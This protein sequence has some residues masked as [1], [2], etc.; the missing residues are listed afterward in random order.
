MKGTSVASELPMPEP[1]PAAR[2]A[3][4]AIVGGRER[5]EDCAAIVP[6]T[7]PEGDRAELLILAD[8]MGGHARG[9]VA[10]QTAINAFK[11]EFLSNAQPLP[12]RLRAGLAA[13]NEAIC[14]AVQRDPLLRG[15]GCTLIGAVVADGL[16][17][18]ISV[19]DSPLYECTP[20]KVRLINR[21]HSIG[22]QVDREAERGQRSADSAA[23][24]PQRHVLLSAVM[25]DRIAMVDEGTV[26][27]ERGALVLLASDGIETLSRDHIAQLVG[28]TQQPQAAVDTILARITEGMKPDQDNTTIIATRVE[29]GGANAAGATPPQDRYRRVK[30]ALALVLL[31]ASTAALTSL[32]WL[33]I[34]HATVP[35]KPTA[36]APDPSATATADDNAPTAAPVGQP[37]HAGPLEGWGLPKHQTAPAPHSAPAA[38]TAP[39]KAPPTI[40]DKPAHAPPPATGDDH[41]RPGT[42]PAGDAAGAGGHDAKVGN[43]NTL[44]PDAVVTAPTPH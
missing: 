1:L 3:L 10:S 32:V 28:G 19:G 41:P 2:A 34:D 6:F 36:A 31:I 44:P 25:G 43:A 35:A 24:D 23:S 33:M 26:R 30:V 40:P 29:P 9:D 21:L 4:G 20:Q 18:W 15:M 12:D 11:A 16:I 17:T 13:A 7:S 38:H 37:S 8:G 42:K 22:A 27:L 5:Q 14:A 39:A